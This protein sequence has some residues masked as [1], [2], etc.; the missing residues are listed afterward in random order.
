LWDDVTTPDQLLPH[1]KPI[2]RDVTP[3]QRPS[4]DPACVTILHALPLAETTIQSKN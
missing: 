3:L 2:N 4:P 1:S